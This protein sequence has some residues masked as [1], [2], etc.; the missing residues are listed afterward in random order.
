MSARKQ[1]GGGLAVFA[2]LAVALSMLSLPG[3]GGG[4]GCA[5]NPTGPGCV[6][7]PTPT[8]TP[9]VT[10]IVSQG[11]DSLE[12]GFLGWV[13]F[14]TTTAGTLGVEVNWTFPTNDVD[15]FL[16]RGNDPCTDET[17]DNRT[18][19]FVATEE[20]ISMKPEKL[21]VPNMAAG[22]YTLYIANFGDTDE[23]VAWQAT[24]T[25][26]SASSVSSATTATVRR[27]AA[28]GAVSRILELR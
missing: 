6:A 1:Y 16:A 28:K 11:N 25:S 27:S 19:S 23:S 26:T 5:G 21:S 17:F 2:G 13:V 3:C 18:C 8:P 9:L 12:S 20:S 10:R 4:G 7:S 22:T 15:I 24:L 14:T